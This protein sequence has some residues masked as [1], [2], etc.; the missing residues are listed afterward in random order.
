MKTFFATTNLLLIASLL[1][2]LYSCEKDAYDPYADPPWLKGSIIETLENEGNYSILLEL[3][4][5][6]GYEEPIEKGLFTVFAANDSAYSAYFKEKGI[7]S[8]NEISD[9][10]AFKL[11]TLNVMN[12]PRTRKQLIYDY[13][14]WHGG[15]QEPNSEIGALLWRVK[16]RSESPDYIDDVKYFNEFIGQKLK[17]MGQQKMVPMFSTEFFTEYGANPDGSDYNYFFPNT[18]WS[19]LQW[20]N[21][22]VVKAEVKASN[23]F[24]Y[25]LDKAVPEIPSI[26]EYLRNNQDEFSVFYDLMQRFAQYSFI[27]YD[28]DAD[29]TRLYSKNYSGV[30]NILSEAGPSP[31]DPYDRRNSYSAFIPTNEVLQKYI[32]ETFLK[33]FPSLDSVPD[34]TLTFLAQSCL[35]NLFQLPSKMKNNLINA[36]GDNIAI[37]V[38]SDVDEAILLSNDPLYKM[39]KYYP[40]RAFTST[41]KPIFF[42]SLHTTFLYAVSGAKMV[43]SL[44]SPDLNVIVFAPTNEGLLEGGIRYFKESRVL[45]IQA[46]DKDWYGMYLEEG[47]LFVE[48]HVCKNTNQ[49][50]S[51][52]GF[53]RMSSGNYIYYNN[54]TI[55]AGG[56]Q[57]LGNVA[58]IVKSEHGDNGIL[59][60]LDKAII[61][62]KNDVARF[63]AGDDDLIEFYGLIEEAGLADSLIS[64]RTDLGYPVIKFLVEQDAWTV[65]AP[66]NDAI[67]TARSNGLIPTDQ[68]ELESFIRYHFIPG[69]VIFDDG[70][71][72]GIT[73]SAKIDSSTVNQVYYAP[74]EIKNA[75]NKLSIVDNVGNI[76]NVNHN[77]AN[78]LVKLGVLHKINKILQN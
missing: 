78:N 3:M 41:I 9:D 47:K 8:V 23:G 77:S 46:E 63:I 30:S 33:S 68:K 42:N 76:V 12:T 24:I 28:D 36:Y 50:F 6:A 4:K 61:A 38:Y 71:F 17:V 58:K 64:E 27:N 22:N 52:E 15:W 35:V 59:L 7:G 2:F 14:Q 19:G 45:Q 67:N 66:T 56:N 32:N 55:Q 13:L 37:D 51:G 69:N 20:Y 39:N 49:D 25:Y 34:I 75:K 72:N 74:V 26:D 21:A 73:S 54:N 10:E 57:E 11:F 43:A 65:F 60:T 48:D 62:P 1:L 31:G 70:E 16:T 18:K 5:K 53:Q 29:K 40:P 44:T